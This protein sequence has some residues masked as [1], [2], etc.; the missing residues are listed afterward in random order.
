M[1]QWNESC[2]AFSKYSMNGWNAKN[3]G[4]KWLLFGE[5][6]ISAATTWTFDS[7][8]Y[9]RC[10][11]L[12]CCNTV[13]VENKNGTGENLPNRTNGLPVYR[14]WFHAGKVTWLLWNASLH[15]KNS[16]NW[17]NRG[18][19]PRKFVGI[20]YFSRFDMVFH[21]VKRKLVAASVREKLNSHR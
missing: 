15:N 7:A 20:F 21:G 5:K 18:V 8:I 19:R 12:F 1:C 4:L 16:T 10:S 3:P 2:S 17:S 11:T 9:R 13:A 6:E 14:N